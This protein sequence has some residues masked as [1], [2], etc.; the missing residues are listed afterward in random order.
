ML[1]IKSLITM[2]IVTQNIP[3]VLIVQAMFDRRQF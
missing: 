3:H 2:N 1:V